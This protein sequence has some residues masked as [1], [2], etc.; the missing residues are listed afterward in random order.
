[1]SPDGRKALLAMV[2][3]F[4]WP[5]HNNYIFTD[6]A[7]PPAGVVAVESRRLTAHAVVVV[8]GPK[9]FQK[10][11]CGGEGSDSLHRTIC[12]VHCG[13]APAADDRDIR[14]DLDEV[15]D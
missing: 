3:R 1:M 12:H 15:E 2:D 6:D 9:L 7:S 4:A 10:G 8:L 14:A 11:Y 13:L 5:W